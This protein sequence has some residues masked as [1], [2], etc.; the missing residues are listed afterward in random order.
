MNEDLEYTKDK[1]SEMLRKQTGCVDANAV[2]WKNVA[3]PIIEQALSYQKQ[4][5]EN[6]IEEC[7]ILINPSF[8]NKIQRGVFIEKK[9]LKSK[10]K[11]MK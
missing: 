3:I 11:E 6:A 4:E 9:E 8:N 10:I 7:S 5:F 1:F 2:S